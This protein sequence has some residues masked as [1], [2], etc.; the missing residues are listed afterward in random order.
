MTW[1]FSY[2]RLSH[3][4][5]IYWSDSTGNTEINRLLNHLEMKLFLIREKFLNEEKFSRYYKRWYNKMLTVNIPTV[6]WITFPRDLSS[7]YPRLFHIF[8]I[9]RKVGWTDSGYPLKRPRIYTPLLFS[10]PRVWDEQEEG[11][12][13]GEKRVALPVIDSFYQETP[14]LP[15]LERTFFFSFFLR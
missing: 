3:G 13:P 10:S 9:T 7:R 5:T 6:V 14:L 2:V 1:Q 11:E 4:T 12:I 15:S 8:I